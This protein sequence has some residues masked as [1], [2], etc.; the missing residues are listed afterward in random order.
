MDHAAK[1]ELNKNRFFTFNSFEDDWNKPKNS[2]NNENDI[3][4]Q[5]AHL[6]IAIK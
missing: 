6:F 4:T 5:T 3:K 1:V 2:I